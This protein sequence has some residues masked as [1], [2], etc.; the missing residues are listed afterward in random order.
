M[1][2]RIIVSLIVLAISMFNSFADEV[3]FKM[4]ITGTSATAGL[5]LVRNCFSIIIGVLFVTILFIKLKRKPLIITCILILWG[6]SLCNKVV[7][8]SS[9]KVYYGIVFFGIYEGEISTYSGNTSN[10]FPIK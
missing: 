9:N 6:F 3:G 2:I 10:E 1:K 7:D 4:L 8:S 5:V